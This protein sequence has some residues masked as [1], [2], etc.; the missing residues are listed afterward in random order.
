M[1]DPNS[2]ATEVELE[3]RLSEPTAAV[4][5]TLGRLSGDI[6]V[7][8]VA[9]KMGPTL[10]RMARRASDAAGV[11]RRVIGVS[12]FSAGNREALESHGIE[13]I[14]CDLLDEAEVAKLPDAA[15]VVF[16]A[17]MKFGS[18]G[19][20]SATWAM[21]SYLPGVACRKYNRSRIVAFS[22]GN[23]YGLAPVEGSGSREDDSP[24]PVGEYAMSCLG[25]E[26]IL[27]YFSRRLGIPMAIIRLNY[28]CELRYGVLV[29]IAQRAWAGEPIELG[30]GY[31][32]TIWQGDA[33]ALT[34]RAF[35]Q[36]ATPPWVVNVTGVYR[37][38]VRAVGE[39]FGRLLGRPVRFARTESATALLSDARIG[40]ERLGAPR[41]PVAQ[42]ITWVADWVAR[43]EKSLGKPTHFGSRDG[44]F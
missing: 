22:T 24:Q 27:E 9:G 21:N 33:N 14:A 17:G 1:S 6:L 8:G 2:I 16:M 7:L 18:T 29:D 13:T 40:A 20:E 30:M 23:V 31:F 12:R 35:D 4:V 41:V 26:R 10:A 43:G 34:L 37:L 28:A 5:E 25:R 15:N 3:D 11:R 32:N 42:L 38:S 19:N 36:L 39:Q 44:S